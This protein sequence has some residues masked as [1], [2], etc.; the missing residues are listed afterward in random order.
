MSGLGARLV[1][2]IAQLGHLLRGFPGTAAYWESRY[3]RGGDSGSGSERELAA[4]KAEVINDFV[5]A[6][7]VHSVIEFGCGDGRQLQLARYPSYVGFDISPTAIARC[8]ELFRADTGKLFRI[9]GEWQGEQS[10]LALSLDVIYHLVEDAVFEEYMQRL[11][12]SARRWVIVYSSNTDD[13]TG[14]TGSHIRHR[15]FSDW[16]ALHAPGWTLMRHIPNRHP[17]TQF[18]GPGTFADFYIYQRSAAAE[19]PALP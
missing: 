3:A 4:F 18:N 8:R 14:Y 19:P 11:F 13:N 15:C 10:D 9:A 6:Q 1:Q 12:R 16:V 7:G 5:V 2:R 17:Q